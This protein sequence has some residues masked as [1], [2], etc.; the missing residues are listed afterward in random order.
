MITIR[1]ANPSDAAAFLALKSTLDSETDLMMFEPGERVTTVEQKR[2]GLAALA[3]RANSTI[4]VAEEGGEL[5]GYVQADGGEYRRNR[6]SAHIIIGVRLASAG[7]GLGTRLLE[8]L[9]AWAREHGLARLELTVQA[10]NRAAIALYRKLGFVTE[11]TR[12][13][14][15]RV[16]GVW[17]DELSMAKLL[18]GATGQPDVE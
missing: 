6:H 1:A 16:D 10:H 15:L 18:D 2:A 17:V 12:R 4:L 14:S 11:G 13:R 3:S 8:A 5:A 9:D 7:Q